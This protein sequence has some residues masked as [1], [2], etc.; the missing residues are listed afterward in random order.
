MGS[1]GEG[2]KPGPLTNCH[3]WFAEL[4]THGGATRRLL[5]DRSWAVPVRR[6]FGRP[7]VQFSR[8]G[9]AGYSYRYFSESASTCSMSAIVS[10]GL[11]S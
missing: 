11:R 2:A 3:C 4:I 5:R 9:P 1:L 8:R 10:S 7:V 6:R